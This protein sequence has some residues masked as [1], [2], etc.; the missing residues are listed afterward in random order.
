MLLTD[1]ISHD[2]L[3]KGM[4]R[5]KHPAGNLYML[6]FELAGLVSDSQPIFSRYSVKEHPEEYGSLHI[7][8]WV[9]RGEY[10]IHLDYHDE[11]P[12]EGRYDEVWIYL[13]ESNETERLDELLKSLLD[14]IEI[15]HVDDV[16]GVLDSMK[17]FEGMQN[18]ARA[19]DPENWKTILRTYIDS[20]DQ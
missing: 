6:D 13:D 2:E 19:V 16:Q 15:Y 3:Y 12:D 9:R 17:N 4:L 11:G 18:M 1:L 20:L 8:Q 14:A 5:Q 10:L 7:N